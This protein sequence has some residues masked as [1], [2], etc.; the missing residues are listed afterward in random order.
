M[1][2]KELCDIKMDITQHLNDIYTAF[3]TMLL[4]LQNLFQKQIFLHWS[5]DVLDYIVFH[6]V[7]TVNALWAVMNC[8]TGHNKASKHIWCSN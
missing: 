3:K 4:K 8:V 5:P 1:V 6:W 7:F 2:S